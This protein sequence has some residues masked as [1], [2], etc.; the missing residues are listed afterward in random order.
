M[1]SLDPKHS[2][3]L[4]DELEALG[5]DDE[6]FGRLHHYRAKERMAR[7][8]A[9][10]EYCARIEAFHEDGENERVQ[11]RLERVLRAYRAGGFES[12]SAPIFVALA[13]AAYHDLPPLA[14]NESR[15]S[16]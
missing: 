11:R 2:L 9:H 8:Q 12:R 14:L 5:F 7:I 1:A 10:R 3:A 4:L 6:A 13:D 16:P 15:S